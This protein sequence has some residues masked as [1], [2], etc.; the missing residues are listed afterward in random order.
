MA[1]EKK[2]NALLKMNDILRIWMNKVD[3]KRGKT[4][5]EARIL[6]FG[7]YKLGVSSKN[8]DIDSII[9]VPYYV[10]RDE[11][12]FGDLFDILYKFHKENHF[13]DEIT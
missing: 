10:D 2:E 6:C 11:D 4:G 3:Q 1:K 8:G 5:G 13:V 9:L 7:S 12:F